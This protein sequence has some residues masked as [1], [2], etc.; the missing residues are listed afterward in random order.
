MTNDLIRK[1]PKL[2]SLLRLADQEGVDV[3]ALDEQFDESKRFEGLYVFEPDRGGSIAVYRYLPLDLWI[4]TL[5][6]EL[7]HHFTLREQDL[8]STFV[9]ETGDHRTYDPKA[10]R[11]S[12]WRRIN[13]DE[14]RADAW[15]ARM[16]VSPSEWTHAELKNPCNL[17]GILEDLRLPR[18][19]G[20][21]WRGLR[22]RQLSPK[23]IRQP[24]ARSVEIE[25]THGIG[26]VQG[27]YQDLL[28]EVVQPG[29]SLKLTESQFWLARERASYSSGGWLKK[30][31]TLMH[32]LEPLF[33]GGKTFEE[34]ADTNAA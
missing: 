1:H 28:R 5:A 10:K 25:L 11:W 20:E 3:Q 13:R 7:G 23:T 14:R 33:R 24:I 16:L 32:S 9:V 4:W 15:A 27:G 21:A 31:Q 17:K 22:A 29:P 34:V 19:A 12:K 8:F 18:R 30:Y 2:R 26:T 6:H